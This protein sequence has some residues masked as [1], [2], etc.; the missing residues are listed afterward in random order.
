M[1]VGNEPARR[2]VHRVGR[3]V[4]EHRESGGIEVTGVPRD[5]SR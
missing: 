5:L 1:L 3:E 2:L 4:T